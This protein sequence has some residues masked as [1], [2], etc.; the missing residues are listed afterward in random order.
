M[1]YLRSIFRNSKSNY[2]LRFPNQMLIVP[3]MPDMSIFTR[4]LQNVCDVSLFPIHLSKQNLE[5]LQPSA[6]YILSTEHLRSTVFL[7]YWFIPR[8][9]WWY[10]LQLLKQHLAISNDFLKLWFC[11]SQ[12]A[13]KTLAVMYSG[14]LCRNS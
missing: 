3:D 4:V 2:G 12:F 8:I 11:W 13:V 14:T 5:Y 7:F 1:Q 10:S 6:M 9:Y